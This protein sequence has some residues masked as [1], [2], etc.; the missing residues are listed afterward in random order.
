MQSVFEY[1][2]CTKH[3]MECFINFPYWLLTILW[4]KYITIQFPYEETVVWVEDS[5]MV[6]MFMSPQNSYVDT[7]MPNVMVLEDGAFGGV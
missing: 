4:N 1:L 5:V 7:L 3:S 2:K 6:W